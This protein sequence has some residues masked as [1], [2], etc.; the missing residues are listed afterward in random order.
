[1][2]KTAT[3]H[4]ILRLLMSGLLMT[5]ICLH[6]LEHCTT[7]VFA[8]QQKPGEYQVKAAFLYNFINFVEWPPESFTDPSLN[9][10]IVGEDPFGGAFDIM[11]NETIRG[12]KLVVKHCRISDELK[13]CNIVFI[14]AS[15]K[16]H[17]GSILRF[18]GTANVLTVSDTEEPVR[19]GVIIGFFI[20]DSKVRF[21]INND[22][23]RR[24]GLKL[25]AKLLKLAKIIA[26]PQDEE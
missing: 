26:V 11:R 1:M 20:E 16:K 15:E 25:S 4:R 6:M 7:D 3:S 13:S 14:P 23:A 10:C 12:K 21:A 5:A 18:I 19:Q 22:T 2:R 9:I 24:A 17:I 8:G